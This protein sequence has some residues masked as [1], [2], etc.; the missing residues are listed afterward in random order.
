[1]TH[2]PE[3]RRFGGTSVTDELA[4]LARRTTLADALS[5]P[6]ALVELRRALERCLQA[7]DD[8]R[9]RRSLAHA[10]DADSYRLLCEAL[11]RCIDSPLQAPGSAIVRSFA[12]P[13]VLVA[14]AGRPT[15]VPGSLSDVQAIRALF[16][17]SHALGPTRNFGLSNA[18]CSLESL[19]AVSPVALFRA[20][21]DLDPRA[22]GPSLPPAEIRL[23]P[24]REQT[25][26]RF[27]VGA[28]VTS[29]DAPG[30]TETAANIAGWGREFANLLVGQLGGPGLQLLALPRPPR[31]LVMAPNVG[32]CAQLETALSLFASNAVRRLRAAV[33]EPVVIVSAHD[34]GEIRVTL[35][36]PFAPEMVEGYRWPLHPLD[37]LPSIER[38]VCELFADMRVTDVR[39]MPRLLEPERASAVPLYPR[40]DEWDALCAGPL[41]S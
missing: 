8:A 1:M 36:S 19:E 37:D 9:W 33:G 2:L 31:D 13:I 29:S 15:R 4:D 30:F 12:I 14:A 6:A 32:R 21:H 26:L 22:I 35:S 39:V 18:L 5:R 25:H 34:N 7:G 17:R 16:E 40:C 20:A 23:D 27:L 11:A 38:T 24:N 28:G 41:A 10:E 3:P